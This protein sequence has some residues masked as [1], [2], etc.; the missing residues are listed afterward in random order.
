[1]LQNMEQ[2]NWTDGQK[3]RKLALLVRK[4]VHKNETVCHTIK[5]AVV[6]ETLWTIVLRSTLS[7]ACLGCYL[8]RTIVHF[9]T[10][11][12]SMQRFCD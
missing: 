10:L 1:M 3:I 6:D 5:Y 4:V 11:S 12:W 7:W 2:R 8:Q 9:S